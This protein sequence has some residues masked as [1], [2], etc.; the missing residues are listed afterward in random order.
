MKEVICFLVGIYK[1]TTKKRK[2]GE[3]HLAAQVLEL[4]P[5]PTKCWHAGA[6]RLKRLGMTT[7]NQIAR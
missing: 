4:L 7:F 5:P 6:P 3:G 1:G 2:R